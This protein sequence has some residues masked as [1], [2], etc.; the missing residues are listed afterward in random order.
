MARMHDYL[1]AMD[2]AAGRYRAPQPAARP[3]VLAALGPKMLA[4][5][6][7]RSDGA[8]TY[9]V[10]PEHTAQARA[11]SARTGCWR[12]SRR[13]CSKPIPGP[14]GRSAGATPGVLPLVNYT[15]NL[16][17]L[18]FD[19]SDFDHEGSDR[20]VDAVVAWG[21]IDA[22]LRRIEDQWLAGADHVCLQVISRDFRHLPRRSWATLADALGVSGT[23][24]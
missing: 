24:G 18:G 13:W 8:H 7:E 6:A 19:D 3:R 21:D 2:Q 12:S 23:P 1:D 9:F 11:S 20:L 5:A 14:P 4:L 17:R 10:P 22:V 16:R 15:E